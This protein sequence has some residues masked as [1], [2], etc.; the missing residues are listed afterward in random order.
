MGEWRWGPW[1]G[2]A[3]MAAPNQGLQP[4]PLAPKGCTADHPLCKS[5]HRGENPELGPRAEV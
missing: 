4:W 1:G 2:P 3:W 5:H